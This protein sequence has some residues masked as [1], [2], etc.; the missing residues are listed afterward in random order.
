LADG[1]FAL[2]GIQNAVGAI[3]G[4]HIPIISPREW[5]AD[6]YNRKGFHSILLQGVV[7]ADY[8]F[9]HFD[10]GRP[11]CMHDYKMFSLSDLHKRMERGELGQYALLG[12]A[13]Y[14]PR[15]NMLTPFMGTKEG[16]TRDKAY[17]NFIQSSSRMAVE[18]ALGILKGRWGSIALLLNVELLFACKMVAA[19]IVLHNMCRVHKESFQRSW[20]DETADELARLRRRGGGSRSRT[21]AA[22]AALERKQRQQM[23]K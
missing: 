6:Y 18:C 17:W 13:A 4:S 3:D 10:I 15:L 16:L 19:C 12:D 8:K 9:W 5:P 23:E 22:A 20:F 1:F 7:D 14:Q 11:G 2:Q 21:E